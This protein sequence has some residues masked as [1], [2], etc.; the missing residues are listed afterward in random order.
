[1]LFYSPG[2]HYNGK[3]HDI[4]ATLDYCISK[5]ES[6]VDVVVVDPFNENRTTKHI[7]FEKYLDSGSDIHGNNPKNNEGLLNFTHLALITLSTFY[8]HRGQQELQ[9][10]S[11]IVPE[12]L[13]YN[14]E[15]N[16][17]YT[18]IWEHKIRCSFSQH[19]DG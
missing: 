3:Y 1:M 19:A 12:E 13:S 5:L 17:H 10:A 11:F 2:Y 15:K 9:S 18:A 8:S 7:I 6:L 4:S 16:S 14:K